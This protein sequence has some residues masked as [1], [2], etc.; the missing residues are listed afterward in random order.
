M[1]LNGKENLI[2]QA[3]DN[4]NVIIQPSPNYNT[5]VIIQADGINCVKINQILKLRKVSSSQMITVDHPA[6]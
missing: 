1:S 6:R 4:I 3:E 5:N 2:I